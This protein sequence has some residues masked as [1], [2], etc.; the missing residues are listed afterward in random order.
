LFT[1]HYKPEGDGYGYSCFQTCACGTPLIVN[2]SFYQNQAAEI[3]M[4]D[5]ITCIDISKRNIL[6]N[7]KII[8]KFSEPE[9]YAKLSQ[10][11][12]NRFKEYVN[13]DEEFIKVKS[14]L[15][16]LQ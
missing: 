14:F 6:E 2:K 11:T 13:F 16:N 5:Q 3:L 8:R 7:A 15:E 1:W 9:E 4:E 10:Q 12:Y